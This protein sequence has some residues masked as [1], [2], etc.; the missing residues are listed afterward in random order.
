MAEKW[1]VEV[2]PVSTGLLLER[3][4]DGCCYTKR[5]SG[6]LSAIKS[7]AWQLNSL[8]PTKS[9]AVKNDSV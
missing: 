6:D 9:E 4:W 3:C 7:I 2:A 1:I 8:E 5:A